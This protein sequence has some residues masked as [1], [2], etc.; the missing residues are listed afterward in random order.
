MTRG[1]GLPRISP[2]AH[3]YRWVMLAGVWLL[4]FCFGLTVVAMAPLVTPITEELGLS[5]SA[6]GGV[7]GAWPLV[8]IALAIPCGV[9]LDRVGARRSLFLAAVII[10]LSGAL[11]GLATDHLSLFLAVG[12]F[13]LGGPLLSVGAPKLIG[14]W[15]EGKERGLA[16]GVYV[17]GMALGGI[18]AL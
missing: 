5:R 9:L 7:L 2:E 16:M 10:G 3:P 18:V 14:L 15:F 17:T 13:G 11:R 6:M 8:Y 12:V 1:A 4:Y